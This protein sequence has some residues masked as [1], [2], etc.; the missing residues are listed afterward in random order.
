MKNRAAVVRMDAT[1]EDF[2]SRVNAQMLI[3]YVI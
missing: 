3:V 1:N 2:T